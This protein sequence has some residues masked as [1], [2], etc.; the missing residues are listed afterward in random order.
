MILRL[1]R[2]DITNVHISVSVWTVRY[3]CQIFLDI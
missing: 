3:C 2:R 1:I